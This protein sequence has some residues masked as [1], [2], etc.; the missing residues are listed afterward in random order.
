[1]T[2]REIAR[3]RKMVFG[4][5]MLAALCT[6]STA[7]PQRARLEM[8]RT[9][10]LDHQFTKRARRIGEDQQRPESEFATNPESIEPGEQLSIVRSLEAEIQAEELR[11]GPN[12][13]SLIELLEA[14]GA[15]YQDFGFDVF[16]SR[17][18]Q[19]ALE[20]VRRT[21]GLH[22]LEQAPLIRRLIENARSIGAF[23]S[24]WDNE[25]Y[26]LELADRHPDDLRTA[27]ILHE[28]AAGRMDILQR[29]R[30]GEFPAEIFIGC[31][32]QPAEDPLQAGMVDPDAVEPNAFDCLSGSRRFVRDRL[33]SEAEILY[34]RSANVLL[35]NDE[36]A[37]P[38]LSE[39]LME[40]ARISYL[41]EN[42]A[43]GARSLENLY[44]CQLM[45]LAT[46]MDGMQ[47][48]IYIADWELLHSNSEIARE[49]ALAK[50]HE[51]YSLLREQGLPET[52]VEELFSPATP[53]VLPAFLP[54]L[55]VPE[56][57]NERDGYIDFAFEI[58]KF[59]KGKDVQI[60]HSTSSATR[61]DER[62][63]VELILRNRFRPMLIEG[64]FA[65]PRR[66]V[67]RYYLSQ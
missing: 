7:W 63:L 20:I 38:E 41:S 54:N 46:W 10:Y 25:Q 11:A 36:C 5:L 59:G 18:H 27:E 42:A 51:A 55:L 1:M 48:F 62:R 8:L 12:S 34:G 53:I 57:A 14:L 45:D 39:R 26:L 52:Y 33:L 66:I 22:S 30:A 32:Y 6:Y 58:T 67:M 50:Y 17:V 43:Q 21:H 24:A 44:A 56:D 49:E 47:T 60:L 37:S 40:I 61:A 64:Q 15:V 3:T 28:V 31:Y 19:R 65:D 13:A 23:Q 35:A 29:Y 4:A 16:A 2:S 9:S